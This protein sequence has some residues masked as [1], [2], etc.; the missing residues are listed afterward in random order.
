MTGDRLVLSLTNRRSNRD[1]VV[2]TVGSRMVVVGTVDGSADGPASPT[3]RSAEGSA[4]E[5]AD[6][7][8]AALPC[9]YKS[10]EHA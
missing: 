4:V 1:T 8:A 2:G 5:P 3:D 10:A 7:P 9:M 6:E